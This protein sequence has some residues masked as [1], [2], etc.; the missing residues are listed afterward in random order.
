M[1][2]TN[3]PYRY[4]LFVLLLYPAIVISGTLKEVQHIIEQESAPIGVV[5]EILENEEKDITWTLGIVDLASQQLKK[6]F[7][8][9][10]I[11]VVSHGN[12]LFALSKAKQKSFK[13]VHSLVEQMHRNNILIQV[14]GTA[15]SWKN[16]SDKDFP[17]YIDVVEA[18]PD[19]IVF[20]EDLGYRL[21]EVE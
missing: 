12:E 4:I 2:N 20:Y 10:K 14:C 6:Q 9:I 5:F 8:K 7:P 11:A 15:A 3:K 19:K 18:A 16:K 17:D 21:I 13:K 1:K